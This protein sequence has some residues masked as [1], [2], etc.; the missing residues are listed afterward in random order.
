MKRSLRIV[1]FT[2]LILLGNFARLYASHI[3]GADF[4]YTH[5][6][7]NTYNITM[8]VYGDCNITF[9]STF[10][11]LSSSSP[12][13]EIYNGTTLVTTTSLTIQAPSAGVEVTPVCAA[14][15]GSTTCVS[16][17]GTVPGVKK[18]TYSSNVNL[19]TTSANWKFVFNGMMSSTVQAGRSASITNITAP[20][21]STSTTM[22]LE[23]TLNN[24]SGANSSP[25]YTTIPTPFFCINKA[26]G[27][28]PGTV[29]PNSDALTYSLVPG[30]D[31]TT[32]SSV[33]YVTG[34]SATS[35]LA[36]ATGT[37]SFSTTNG[38]LN[39]T[40]NAVQRSLVVTKVEEYRG[41]TLVGSSMRE[42]TFVVLNN[43]SNSAPNGN[44]SSI[45]GGTIVDTV[46]VKACRSAGNISF[47]VN[48]TDP[49][50]DAI[51]VQATGLPTGATYTVS[52]N[53]TATPIGTFN[54]NIGSV[55]PGNYTFFITFTD[56]GCPLSS[57]QTKA[58][59]ITVLPLPTLSFA[60]T[61][62]ATCVRPGRF[63]ITP[64][65]ASS[66]WTINILQGSTTLHTFTGVTGTQYDSLD[67]GTYVI[68]LINNNGCYKDTTITIA[69]PPA[70]IPS[71]AMVKPTCHGGNDGSITI[72]GANGG[73]PFT[74]ALGTGSYS[75]TNTFTG[76][77]S[78]TYTLH[79]KDTNQCV[80]DTTVS[81]LDPL[82]LA[83]NVTFVQPP[84]NYY[85]S[86]VITVN[87]LN[88]KTPYQYALDAGTFGTTNV[89]SGLFGG[90]YTL[91]IK[92]DN[93]CTRDT[94]IELPNKVSVHANAVVTDV[95]CNGATT[96]AVTLTA[97]GAKSPYKYKL[98]TGTLGTIN[99]FT[100]LPAGTHTFHIEDSNFCYLDTNVIIT[101]PTAITTPSVITHI[102]CFGQV[103][104][105]INTNATGGT[106][107]YTYAINAGTYS[108]ANTFSGLT[109]GAHVVHI[110]DA[111][112]CIKDTT[113]TII[114]P[115]I[116]K[117]ANITATQPNCNGDAN[118]IFTVT[119]TGGTI[120]YT[121]A[122]NS[123]TFQT[124]NALTGLNAGTYTINVK[125][126]R[127]CT[128]D[129]VMTMTEPTPL[130]I[131]AAVK[132][133]TCST[134]ANGVV[135][136]TGAGGVPGYTYNYNTS[137]FVS[138][139]TFTPLPSGFYTFRVRDSKNC[140]KDTLIDIVDSLIIRPT[141][142]AT[143]VPCFGQS[144]G[145]ITAT[146]SGGINPYDYALGTGS[147]GAGNTFSGL[148][149]GTYVV[150]IQDVNG[151]KRDTTVTLTQPSKLTSSVSVTN[152]TCNGAASGIVNMFSTGGVTP[153]T[154]A[155]GAG[156]FV[157]S[158]T[159][160]FIKAGTFTFR[161]KDANN[162]Q[163]DTTLTLTEP[164]ALAFTLAVTNVLCFGEKSGQVV[165]NGT[166]GTPAYMYSWDNN[167]G[168]TSNVLTGLGVG[169]RAIHLKDQF[170][171]TKDTLIVLTQPT[172]MELTSLSFEHPTCKT[173]AD[174]RFNM[175]GK[176]GTPPY[177]YGWVNG[178]SGS[179]PDL[180]G[181]P[182]GTYNFFMKDANG[183]TIDTLI[184]LVGKSDLQIGY[185]AAK[186]VSCHDS[187]NGELRIAPDGGLQPFSFSVNGSS[188]QADAIWT[189]LAP[190]TYTMSITDSFNCSV[191]TSLTI[192][193][194]PMLMA[195]A[196]TLSNN[197]CENYDNS[198]AISLAVEGGTAPYKYL[199]NT[200][201]PRTEG[202]IAG[203]ANGEYTVLITDANNCT[204]SARAAVNYDNCCKIF[205]PDAFTPNNDGKNDRAKVLYK[206]DLLVKRFAIYDRYG[207]MVFETTDPK[208]GW[209]G[210]HNGEP[211][212]LGTYFY[213]MTGICG[214][215]GN[216]EVEYKGTIILVR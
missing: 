176:G 72:S 203:L 161:V 84:C 37:F 147:Y 27:Y 12:I 101:Q 181:I 56:A 17:T 19:G 50:L 104:G 54:W 42:M 80:K 65:D 132:Q 166:G 114:E 162:C 137:G 131:S 16:T 81:L 41:T 95:L 34:Y 48:P 125:D 168:Q 26:A 8:V 109:K 92:D 209:D 44:V 10:N 45:V 170:G 146:P 66:P 149:T 100:G 153:H 49:D 211:Q 120:P 68:R 180:S 53:N 90:S 39:F 171:C 24:L 216:K 124:S 118:G 4:I 191:D 175:D 21:P 77:S 177:S 18:F 158:S 7:G 173:K 188:P 183:C 89:F 213:Y 46:T 172:L 15:L 157:A 178:P 142:T 184:S 148:K 88:G 133:S 135:T 23:A 38:Q 3:Y 9:G 63:T 74:Y 193:A 2:V 22:R 30:L 47:N 99:T 108:A 156:A 97:F 6:S 141:L 215:G 130:R 143:N 151:C 73:P 174:G 71:V 204:N 139:A 85:N 179:N 116:L 128:R 194:P 107:S 202:S 208:A 11:T 110:K 197:D 102:S 163:F 87:G 93:N 64:T 115:A 145:S 195:E 198:G 70:I 29:D 182:Q 185:A 190:G 91:H 117:I 32:G 167:L 207:Q 76:L 58:Y 136:L 98:G 154:Y 206:G 57:K 51:N 129:S 61:G 103:D 25:T 31:A 119:P 200:P 152:P 14:Q 67:P 112:N 94:L 164:P 78:G 214:N 121:Y 62:K 83:A 159:L 165:V 20:P 86:G 36:V 144:T 210:Y 35:P 28:N 43:C 140:I 134:L 169:T 55:T 33:G 1:L 106:P 52:G 59:T 75:S 160:N 96:G 196:K 82:P 201:T 79:I 189:G 122:I 187:R 13:V 126:V 205:I 199:W 111:N 192:S 123:G 105:V 212:D 127:G 40:P 150:K 186:N 138:S 155:V 69:P 113:I 60:L 5:V